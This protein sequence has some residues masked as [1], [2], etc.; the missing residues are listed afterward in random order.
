MPDFDLTRTLACCGIALFA[1]FVDA[2]AGGGGIITIPTIMVAWGL[3]THFV[4]GTNK[5]VGTSGSSTATIA[6]LA[7]GRLDKLVSSLGFIVAFAAGIAGAL[8]L[9]HLGKVNEPLLKAIFG[10]LLVVMALYMFF[11]PQ[12]GG[13]SAYAGPTPRNIAITVASGLVIGFYDGFFGPG[14]G[15]FLVFVMVRWMKFDF[16]VGTGNAKAMNFGSNI[17]SLLT[18]IVQGLVVWHVAL[19]MAAANATG[20]WLGSGLAIKKGAGF[21]RWVFLAAALAIAGRMMVFVIWGK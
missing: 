13:E 5:V 1:G 15:S 18:F 20:A 8:T 6:F 12:I 16:V 4:M 14:T 17:G 7:K 11:K 3:P 21:V 10:T 9:A 19:P 2:M